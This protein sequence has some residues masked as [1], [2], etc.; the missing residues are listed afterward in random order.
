MNENG[1]K[2]RDRLDFKTTVRVS[3]Q[4]FTLVWSIDRLL[5]STVIIVTIVPS[6]I[7]F[8]NMYI[9]KL[10][11]DHVVGL[12]NGQPL[13]YSSL[14]MLF[15]IR[16]ITYFLSDFSWKT[17]EYVERVLWAKLPIRF[18]EIIFRKINSL[19][20]Q[21]FED[22]SFKD[23]LQKVRDNY[24]FRPLQ[25]T[26]YLIFALQSF[27]QVAIAFFALARLNVILL[28]IVALVSIP[29]FMN[30]FRQSKLSWA[31]WS[32]HTPYRKR[33][34][35]LSNLLQDAGHM[36]ELRIFQLGSHFVKKVK[37]I[38]TKFYHENK[39]VL[40][41]NYI[42]GVALNMLSTVIFIGIE[43][44]VI[45]QAIMKKITIGDISFYTGVVTNFQQGLSGLFRNLNGIF[46]NSLYTKSIFDL[47]ETQP[48]LKHA[49][50]PVVISLAEPPLIEFKH[51]SFTYPGST[52]K[53]LDNF[54]LT[55]HPEEKVAF[56]GE[57]GAGKSTIIK[58][59]ARFYDVDEGKILI[60]GIDIKELDLKSWYQYLGILFQDFN[61]Y[62]E[63]VKENIQYG[64][65][66]KDN[67][68][69][70]KHAANSAGADSVIKKLDKGYEQMLGTTFEEGKELSAGQWQKVALA[71]AF[72]RNALVLVLD[73]PTAAIDAK[74]EAEI[75]ERVEQ[76]SKNK[77]VIIISH[78]FSTVRNA[79]R[80]I[81]LDQGKI[82]EEGNHEQLMHKKGLYAELFTIQA[83]GYK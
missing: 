42:I 59:L 71:R 78:R 68:E 77:S 3:W 41:R 50:S 79:D 65:I 16:V 72:F 35:Y 49:T 82:V 55:I 74:A 33:Y 83:K 66:D 18:D 48:I 11:I 75:F 1:N 26:S 6:I 8:I 51:V 10:I 80:I 28:L 25:A 13:S 39:Q 63:L 47:L 9:Y 23:L 7:P 58:L 36:K 37:D 4:L 67:F 52:T 20:M 30:Q 12:I 22:S 62:E 81:V 44:F 32:G 70:I 45:L 15:G 69:D 19:D 31:V 60:N 43:V 38:D 54:S 40:K 34:W 61:R 46:E 53:V 14:Y 57:N 2:K 17:Q 21:Y 73:E 64:R 27:V 76:L 56:V 24:Y 29:E 5:V